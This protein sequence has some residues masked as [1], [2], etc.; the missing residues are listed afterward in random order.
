MNIHCVVCNLMFNF[1]VKLRCPTGYVCPRF[2][3]YGG[4]EFNNS[5]HVIINCNLRIVSTLC[6][7]QRG[8][9]FILTS[10]TS[11][12]DQIL[13][14][15]KLLENL[16][17]LSCGTHSIVFICGECRFSRDLSGLLIILSLL[18]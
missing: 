14:P 8:I 11:Y 16:D 4:I 18:S 13:S 2:G 12:F 1:I 15:L 5:S 6:C 3:S 10:C 9:L 17:T 7:G